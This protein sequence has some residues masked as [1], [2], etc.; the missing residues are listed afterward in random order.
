MKNKRK[1]YFGNNP[2]GGKVIRSRRVA[3]QITSKYHEIQSDLANIKSHPSSSG[4]KKRLQV[5]KEELQLIGGIEAYQ[6][7]SVI[8]TRYFSTSKWIISTL[9]KLIADKLVEFNNKKPRVLEVGA[10]NC[11]L[12]QTHSLQVRAIDLHSQ[13]SSI[14][15]CDFFSIEP[16]QDYDVVVCSMVCFIHFFETKI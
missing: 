5:L 16:M 8:S 2:I 6:Q 3:R 13:H 10:I 15:E 7:A 9:K 4:S 14:E 1:F 11:Y 12:K